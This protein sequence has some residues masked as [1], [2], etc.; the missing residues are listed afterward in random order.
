[1]KEMAAFGWYGK[2]LYLAGQDVTSIRYVEKM[3]LH[4]FLT[5]LSYRVAE[6]KAVNEVD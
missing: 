5:A 2:I 1:M 4:D 6:N 3:K